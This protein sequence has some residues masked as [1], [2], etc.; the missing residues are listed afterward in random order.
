[1]ALLPVSHPPVLITGFW[2]SGTTW[3]QEVIA[4]AL[5]AKT[6]FEP[7]SPKANP[8]FHRPAS[9]LQ[10]DMP[11]REAFIPLDVASFNEQDL[12]FLDAIFAG[13]CPAR[14]AFLCRTSVYESFRRRAVVKLVRGQFV[15]PYLLER[16]PIRAVHVT[17][18][19][20]AV[21]ASLLNT[22]WDWSFGEVRFAN[23]WPHSETLGSPLKDEVAKLI[24]YDE[25]PADE[26]IAAYW[27]FTE[28]QV[29]KLQH[30]RLLKVEYEP[31]VVGGRERFNAILDFLG[32]G[33][34]DMDLDRNS[35]VTVSN[36][37]NISTSARTDSW[38]NTLPLETQDR[39]E[40]I[41]AAI[42]P[43]G[44]EHWFSPACSLVQGRAPE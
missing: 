17:R 39:I 24:G 5:G 26:R 28:K 41:I 35:V 25:R 4:E 1:M 11:H 33:S 43:E 9:G 3:V 12:K 40:D 2:R 23:L 18:H 10:C 30:E 20:C 32:G 7:F 8:P 34:L 22:D 44:A 31:L 36:R 21:V 29:A 37:L 19:P 27:A 42:W 16:Y 38:R 13:V 15:L 6:L 14:F